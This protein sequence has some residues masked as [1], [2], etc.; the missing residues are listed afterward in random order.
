M[1]L[2]IAYISVMLIWA[3][4][5]LAIQWSSE[6]V[7]FLFAIC[8]RF[9]LAAII[10]SAI[11][12]L[13]RKKLPLDIKAIQ[14]YLIGGI[15]LSLSMLIVYWAAPSIP[16]GWISVIFGMS[17]ILTG[18]FAMKILGERG[19]TAI[20]FMAI[21][22]GIAGLY[23]MLDTGAR[24]SEN[25]IY[26]VIAI[27]IGTAF[28]SLNMVLIKKVN[29]DIDSQ[30]TV[31]GTLL[32]AAVMF[33]IIWI[34]SGYEIPEAIPTHASVAIVYLAIIG[35]VIGFLL[36]YYVLKRVEAV[37]MSL[38]TLVTPVGALIIGHIINN[39]P[40]NRDIIVGSI[41]IL[42]GLLFFQFEGAIR[43]RKTT[44]SIRS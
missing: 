21:V 12:L 1:Q 33:A 19:L 10:A 2:I 27:F 9:L 29:A 34:F 24:Y 11:S 28:Y 3:T 32:I 7:G 39:E 4:T 25:A 5:P 26:G 13:I 16:S 15:G 35:S 43:F 14:T 44:N 18:L 30:S 20:R 41:L 6:S 42:S 40:L 17:P 38:I 31:T 8:S 37:R 22:L 36:F 23:I